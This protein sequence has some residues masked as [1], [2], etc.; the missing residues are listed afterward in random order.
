MPTDMMLS[1]AAENLEIK[2]N[3]I[4]EE[5]HR[6][7]LI[8]AL[9]IWISGWVNLI[10]SKPKTI[11]YFPPLECVEVFSDMTKCVHTFPVLSAQPATF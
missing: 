10:N 4:K 7:S 9:H 11:M 5:Q 3:L 6:A 8:K 1:V 2:M